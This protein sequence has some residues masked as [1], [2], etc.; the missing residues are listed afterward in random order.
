MPCLCQPRSS[1][2]CAKLARALSDVADTTNK[3]CARTSILA[4]HA[5]P[6][7][8]AWLRTKEQAVPVSPIECLPMTVTAETYLT[9]R[10]MDY[11]GHDPSHQIFPHNSFIVECH[12]QT[13]HWLL[14]THTH[15]YTHTQIYISNPTASNNSCIKMPKLDE[16]SQWVQQYCLY[17]ADS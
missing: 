13:P 4:R 1:C 17:T 10:H 12:I 11:A 9:A 2:Q 14:H 3:L 8:F 6:A 7:H 16:A 5:S 15:T